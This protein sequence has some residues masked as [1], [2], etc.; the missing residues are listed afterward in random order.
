MSRR[1]TL[2][3]ERQFTRVKVL[4]ELVHDQ[5]LE[6]SPCPLLVSQ[7]KELEVLLEKSSAAAREL[8]ANLED[9][10]ISS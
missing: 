4:L 5:P 10:G 6:S 7:L 2:I 3:E 8:R 9:H 1:F